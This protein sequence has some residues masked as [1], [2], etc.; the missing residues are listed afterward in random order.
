MKAKKLGALLSPLLCAAFALGMAAC[1]DNPSDSSSGGSHGNKGYYTYNTYMAGTNNL[2]WNPHTWETNDDSGLLGYMSMGFFDFVLAENKTS[3]ARVPEMAAYVPGTQKLYEDVTASYAGSYGV[4]EGETAKA[5]RIYLNPAATWDDS[6][7]TPIKAADYIYSMR[8]QLDPVMKNRR[9]DSYYGGD[10]AIYNA[11]NYLYNGQEAPVSCYDSELSSYVTPV[12]GDDGYYRVSDKGGAFLY[13]NLTGPTVWSPQ[14]SI[15]DFYDAGIITNQAFKTYLDAVN[16][17]GLV[18]VD[19]TLMGILDTFTHENGG[20]YDGEWLEICYYYEKMPEMD[21]GEVGLQ[22][23]SDTA[24]GLEYLDVILEKTLA[25]PDFYVPYYLSSTWLVHKDLYEANKIYNYTD[26][27]KDVGK[28]NPDKTLASITS[29]YCT[30]IATSVGYGPYSFTYYEPDKQLTFEKNKSWYGYKDGRHENQFQTDKISIKVIE[31]Q[32]TALL[33]FLNG[34]VDE[35]T[36]VSED[37]EKYSGSSYIDYTPQ[38]HTTKL[39]I[40]SDYDALKKRETAGINKTMLTVRDFRKAIS[41]AIDRQ[42][43]ASKY[44]AAGAAG[45]GLLNSMYIFDPEAST[46]YRSTDA[47]KQA[48]CDLYGIEYGADKEYKTLDEAYGSITG[49]SLTEAKAAMADA[50][51]YATTHDKTGAAVGAGSASALYNGTD[52]ISVELQVYAS[53]DVY[54]QMFNYLNAQI[55]EA[56]KGTSLEGKVELTMTVNPDYYKAIAAGTADMI[57]STWGGAPYNGM[58]ILSNVYCDDPKG[59][60]NQNE[61]GFDTSAISVS[62]ELDVE[63]TL[64][65]T[66]YRAS[67]KNWADW[68]NNRDVTIKSADGKK[69][70][71]AAS[72]LSIGF[73]TSVFAK[74]ESTYLSYF[75][76]IPLYYRNVASLHSAKVNNGTDTYVDLVNFGGIRF[77]TYNYDDAAWAALNKSNIDYTK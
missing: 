61:Y 69:A 60:G 18:K 43:F 26:G 46:P 54:V 2:N 16:S 73:K 59:G 52:K 77:T 17:D 4:G 67:L 71:P 9:A 19:G 41:Y 8:Q 76:A 13:A 65:Y 55:K 3:N 75:T 50:Y 74:M 30:S 35:V 10:F 12:L 45:F 5:F 66:E 20:G 6:K 64:E 62:M 27:T 63:G 14:N 51:A 33:S 29:Q 22:A 70:L 28:Q 21:F 23:G 72:S 44:T 47:G 25:Q 68:L 53:D 36:L 34:D 57:F 24:S 37:M 56:C 48:L 42:E 40:N 11:K 15:K 7:H 31:K 32:A 1:G 58:G 49:Y 38:S 39:T